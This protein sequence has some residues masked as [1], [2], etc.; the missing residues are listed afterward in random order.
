M[1]K[2]LSGLSFN[3][4]PDKSHTTPPASLTMQAEAAKSH[5]LPPPRFAFGNLK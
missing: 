5:T 3:A 4:A 2:V 1:N